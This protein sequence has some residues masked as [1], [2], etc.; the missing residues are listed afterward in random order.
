MTKKL[1]FMTKN[2]D[3]FDFSGGGYNIIIMHFII[4][5]LI[6]INI[7]YERKKFE[8]LQKKYHLHLW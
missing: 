4:Y 1:L 7:L 2:V 8:C 6:S 5:I 3:I